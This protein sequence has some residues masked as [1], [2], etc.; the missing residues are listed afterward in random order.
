MTSYVVVDYKK[1]PETSLYD[2]EKCKE[3]DDVEGIFD[4]DCKK[5]YKA[6]YKLRN[7]YPNDHE[8]PFASTEGNEYVFIPKRILESEL[9]R[10]TYIKDKAP[11]QSCF[12]IDPKD[13]FS[14]H[15]YC[16]RPKVEEEKVEDVK[17]F[18]AHAISFR[19]LYLMMFLM[20]VLLAIMF[21][22]SAIQYY[23][24]SSNMNG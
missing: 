4:V 6:T 21:I 5:S 23:I 12:E 15:I 9:G 7:D 20:L 2:I 14:K 11:K 1:D 22:I 13:E 16:T 10:E 24:W 17:E 18:V 8:F 19:M 3:R